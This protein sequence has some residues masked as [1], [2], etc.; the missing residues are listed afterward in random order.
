MKFIILTNECTSV[1]YSQHMPIFRPPKKK[2][3]AHFTQQMQEQL[4]TYCQ[5]LLSLLKMLFRF[6]LYPIF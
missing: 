3:N 4:Y 6:S 2:R 5:T 1:S